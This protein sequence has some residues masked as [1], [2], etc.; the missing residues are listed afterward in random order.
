MLAQPSRTACGVAMRG[1]QPD[2]DPVYNRPAMIDTKT[3]RAV[4]EPPPT[5]GDGTASGPAALVHSALAE[6]AAAWR[7]LVLFVGEHRGAVIGIALLA[8][9]CYGYELFNF[10]LSIDEELKLYSGDVTQWVSQGRFGIALLKILTGH[11]LV[12]PFFGLALSLGLLVGS[13]AVLWHALAGGQD[14]PRRGAFL[15]FGA[16]YVSCPT[17]PYYLAFETY[18]LEV[19][20][21][22]ALVALGALFLFRSEAGA[23]HRVNLMLSGVLL[24]AAI[25]VYQSL[26]GL[27][28][29]AGAL[30][31]LWR[32]LAQPRTGEQPPGRS[33]LRYSAEFAGV[34][35]A[36]FAVYKVMERLTYLIVAKSPYTESVVK[37]G[38]VPLTATFRSL[39]DFAV[40]VVRGTAFWG[41]SSLW[42][43]YLLAGALVIW[44]LVR[45]RGGRALK[46]TLVIAFVLS[47]FLLVA[48]LG[49]A[50][51]VRSL[52][53]FQLMVA[54]VWGLAF[55]V[56]SSRAARRILAAVAILLLLRQAQ[57]TNRMFLSE[58]MRWQADRDIANRILDRVYGLALPPAGP[59]PVAF[60]GGLKISA[61]PNFIRTDSFGGSFFEWEGGNAWRIMAFV[62][63]MGNQRLLAP[64][65]AQLETARTWA[66][67]MPDWPAAGSVVR[68]DGLVVVKLSGPP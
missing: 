16:F 47:P 22:I 14:A 66:K 34:T 1:S 46:V 5:A 60:V 39:L 51:P 52:Q 8:V 30:G 32:H 35:L 62:R 50:P 58:T 4:V 65:R 45:T 49:W 33:L 54:G 7:E 21:G 67:G 59:V 13:A 55:T 10:S 64:S 17:L 61:D 53:G 3:P 23:R 40:S 19:S 38:T 29:C 63:S 68:Q 12:V 25:S 9:L 27:W 6:V 20:A 44:I 15:A 28:V 24:L 48:V 26:L 11:A 36:A 43:T 2:F 56:A 18:N 37:W 42:V 41:A 31:L 57:D